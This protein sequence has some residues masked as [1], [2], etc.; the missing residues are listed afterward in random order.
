MTKAYF[1]ELRPFAPSKTLMTTRVFD[2]HMN[3]THGLL[4]KASP[5][6]RTVNDDD[7]G[8]D[9]EATRRQP[10]RQRRAHASTIDDDEDRDSWRQRMDLWTAASS[11]PQ[12]LAEALSN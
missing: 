9:D 8:D 3:M 7:K 1:R 2:P 11:K 12:N 4:F 6:L 10:Q 5:P